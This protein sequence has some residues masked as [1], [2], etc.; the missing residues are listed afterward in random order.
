MRAAASSA[1]PAAAASADG[2]DIAAFSVSP[3]A[4]DAAQLSATAN[5]TQLSATAA[6]SL[7]EGAGAAT[8]SD[9]TSSS[10][11][12]PASEPHA[13]AAKSTALC[14]PAAA[15]SMTGD[16]AI[17][18]PFPEPLPKR[19]ARRPIPSARG[20]SLKVLA[21][22]TVVPPNAPAPALPEPLHSATDSLDPAGP[23][24]TRWAAHSVLAKSRNPRPNESLASA[25]S[26]GVAARRAASH[27][28]RMHR[29]P[30]PR[31]A[32]SPARPPSPK[33]SS[34]DRRAF[35]P[36][37]PR[38]AAGLPF[39]RRRP[40]GPDL[41]H[42]QRGRRIGRSFSRR[43]RRAI[44][45]RAYLLCVRYRRDAQCGCIT[46][47]VHGRRW[48]WVGMRTR[49]YRRDSR[50]RHVATAA[51]PPAAGVHEDEDADAG[52]RRRPFRPVLRPADLETA[53]C[54]VAVLI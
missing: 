42:A 4:A 22:P 44:G 41:G 39:S 38:R 3:A 1:L 14:A 35:V 18:A 34:G 8:G 20:P 48:R 27:A 11:T 21:A 13:T 51:L 43:A 37:P 49:S 25:A 24:A 45:R 31:C 30:A 54:F 5:A 12:A 50:R 29:L 7:L 53:A 33:Q 47:C 6:A 32:R 26:P 9:V 23:A 2:M 28:C 40:P 19:S 36:Q 15:C 52:A 46:G 17:A 10:S 16:D